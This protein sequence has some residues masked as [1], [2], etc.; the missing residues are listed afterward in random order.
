MDGQQYFRHAS[1]GT[2]SRAKGV[3]PGGAAAT[4]LRREARQETPTRRLVDPAAARRHAGV[5]GTGHALPASAP[6]SSRGGARE[7][8]AAAL[9][10]RRIRAAREHKVDP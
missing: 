5:R 2:A 4:L 10:E 8:A 7:E 9:G 6:G 1:R 3:R